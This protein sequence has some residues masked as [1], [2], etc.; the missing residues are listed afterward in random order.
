VVTGDHGESLG[1]HGSHGH[2]SSV[3]EPEV[4]TLGLMFVPGVAGHLARQPAVHEDLAPTLAN[5]LGVRGGFDELR[6][7]NLIP[8]FTDHSIEPVSFFVELEGFRANA[9]AIALVDYPYKLIHTRGTSN[10]VLY[11]VEKDPA[12]RSAI[13]GQRPEIAARMQEEIIRHLETAASS[14]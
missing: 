7:R 9:R 14:K 10:Y 5:L 3:F 13:N 11:D 12:E 8:A 1:E 2:Y 4:R 6:G